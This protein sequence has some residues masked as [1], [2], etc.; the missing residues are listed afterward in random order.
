[1]LRAAFII[2]LV[3]PVPAFSQFSMDM[4]YSD[5]RV[6]MGDT[7]L[8]ELTVGD[9]AVIHGAFLCTNGDNLYVDGGFEVA[10]EP[11]KYGNS[12]VAKRN[13]GG[14]FSLSMKPVAGARTT[15]ERAAILSVS[16]A[17]KKCAGIFERPDDFYPISDVM[18]KTSAS[19]LFTSSP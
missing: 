18:G 6:A 19:E 7:P 8:K 5:M 12:L 3:L 11:S 17:S 14:S 9:S 13:P 15:V 10:I 1:M 4:S 16:S 2:G